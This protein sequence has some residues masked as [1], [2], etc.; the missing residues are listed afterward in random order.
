MASRVQFS[1][2]LAKALAQKEAGNAKLKEG[3]FKQA[4]FQYKQGLMFVKAHLPT[5]STDGIV[6]M[7]GGPQQAPLTEAETADAKQLAVVLNSNIAQARLKLEDWDGMFGWIFF[8]LLQKPTVYPH[9]KLPQ[10]FSSLSASNNPPLYYHT[11]CTREGFVFQ[12]S[13][14]SLVGAI[15]HANDA[16]EIDEKF[17][18]AYFRRGVAYL[19]K[20]D[21]ERARSDFEKVA[22]DDPSLV[23]HQM[24]LLTK[25][26][27]RQSKAQQSVY[28]KMFESE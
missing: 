15:K 10:K 12:I 27:A 26:E 13:H 4:S 25:E 24:T 1:D 5:K 9:Q 2:H 20:H 6:N 14:I 28:K 17:T 19:A 8:F 16:L 18:K 22:K 7:L 11:K 21:C 3:S 23:S